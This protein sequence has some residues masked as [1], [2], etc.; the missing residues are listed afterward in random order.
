VGDVD[1]AKVPHHG[2]RDQEP[3][4]PREA[5]AEV[6]V[7]PVGP[8]N[9]GHPT[10]EALRMWGGPGSR[11]YRNDVDGTVEVCASGRPHETEV[12]LR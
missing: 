4:L 11:E 8:N 1:V 9:Y 5:R 3:D 10:T 7:V 2:S 12:H 6:S